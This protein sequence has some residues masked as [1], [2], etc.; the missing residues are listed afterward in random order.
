MK[1][2]LGVLLVLWT[3]LGDPSLGFVTPI[4][5]S[6]H[7]SLPSAVKR[8]Q[9]SSWDDEEY[10]Y[11]RSRPLIEDEE[12][13]LGYG[14]M[15]P[16]RDPYSYSDDLAYGRDYDRSYNSAG[17]YPDSTY[18]PTYD[19]SYDRSYDRDRMNNRGYD[20]SSG[21]YSPSYS[22]GNWDDGD[23]TMRL[24]VPDNLSTIGE[25][26]MRDYPAYRPRG[27][28]FSSRPLYSRRRDFPRE[29]PLLNQD[30]FLT[31][32]PRVARGRRPLRALDDE[33]VDDIVDDEFVPEE[34]FIRS[35]RNQFR[36][37]S[38]S[39]RTEEERIRQRRTEE[40]QVENEE[41]EVE[42]ARL[43]ARRDDG[44]SSSRLDEEEI[45]RLE[46]RMAS[47]ESS[48]GQFTVDNRREQQEVR[49]QT[50]A[51]SFRMENQMD[52]FL[53]SVKSLLGRA[54][55]NGPYSA[56]LSSHAAA[57]R[58]SS[59]A[60]AEFPD[61]LDE[62]FEGVLEEP[63]LPRGSRR[64]LPIET[65]P[66]RFRGARSM[67]AYPELRGGRG[68]YRSGPVRAD[69]HMNQY[70]NKVAAYPETWR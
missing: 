60:A 68:G 42:L 56:R 33:V 22:P 5:N 27:R 62:E 35:S 16:P 6:I 65:N 14:A 70:P 7:S 41:L 48:M 51:N 13:E 34:G 55:N 64:S 21:G 54:M 1:N 31:D 18:R 45:L 66:E 63:Y 43:Q 30:G 59:H 69:T 17:R 23:L 53:N 61:D 4:K 2:N 40:L 15:G 47:L 19:R 3:Q 67:L 44:L 57:D 25:R 39:Y 28:N 10:E 49:R 32:H 26:R 38:N 50:T 8:Q 29:E 20:R 52:S 58:W 12:E 11:D 37:R 36:F 9:A 46:D 24:D